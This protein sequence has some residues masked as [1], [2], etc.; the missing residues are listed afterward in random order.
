M[1]KKPNKKMKMLFL[2]EI[3]LYFFD[4]I[5]IK[6]IELINIVLVLFITENDTH[7]S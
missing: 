1:R 3:Y 4:K 2:I 6:R 7:G 5:L